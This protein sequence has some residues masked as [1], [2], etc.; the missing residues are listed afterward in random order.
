MSRRGVIKKPA[1]SLEDILRAIYP[2][3]T[4]YISVQDISPA[5]LFGG[6]WTRIN[7]R[8][9]LAA[10]STYTAG[11]TGGMASVTSGGS[12]ATNTGGSSAASTGGSSAAT[13]GSTT[14]TANQIPAHTHTFPQG[15]ANTTQT[16][17]K[18]SIM[19]STN[20]IGS[21]YTDQST[22]TGGGQGH[23]HTMSHTHT[24]AHTHTMA[25]THSVATMPPYLVV[26]AWKRLE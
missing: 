9:L 26:Y 3:G 25:H 13:T 10:G 24:I 15:F 20:G 16:P 21:Y 23:T 22:A 14:L 8:F 6:T 11:A 1:K 12:S 2:V 5:E 18:L 4:V 7:D 17:N 19:F